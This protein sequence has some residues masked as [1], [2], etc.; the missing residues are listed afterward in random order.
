MLDENLKF[1]SVCAPEEVPSYIT[2]TSVRCT[3]QDRLDASIHIY[4]LY[5]GGPTYE[6][7]DD[8]EV[9][10]NRQV[11]SHW[12]LPSSELEEMWESLVLQQG[13]KT[14]LI[15]YAKTLLLFSTRGVNSSLIA[16]NRIILLYGPPGTGRILCLCLLWYCD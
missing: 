6:D 4:Q 2:K 16:C 3:S 13:L 14:T 5:E 8:D 12:M 7:I 9:G 1:I 11:A 10:T 15:N